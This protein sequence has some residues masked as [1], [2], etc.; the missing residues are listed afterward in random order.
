MLYKQESLFP[1][2]TTITEPK[3]EPKKKNQKKIL[4]PTLPMK[5]QRFNKA[6]E[7]LICTNLQSGFIFKQ[8]Q[9]ISRHYR[10]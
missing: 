10:C 1:Q 7:M 4:L 2:N 9:S 6:A 5:S 3:A 8:S